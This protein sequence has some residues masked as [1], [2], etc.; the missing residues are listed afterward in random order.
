MTFPKLYNESV[1]VLRRF[2]FLLFLSGTLFFILVTL[3]PRLI[4]EV[5]EVLRLVDKL[6]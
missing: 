1:G 5:N 3:N 6:Q 4:H 2:F